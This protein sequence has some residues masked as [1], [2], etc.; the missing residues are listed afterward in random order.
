M[1]LVGFVGRDFLFVVFVNQRTFT[2]VLLIHFR[3][4][5]PVKLNIILIFPKMQS[6][7]CVYLK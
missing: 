1:W 6:L 4:V 3:I 7:I 2:P 5:F